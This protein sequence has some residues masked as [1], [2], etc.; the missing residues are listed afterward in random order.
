M[1]TSD[2]LRRLQEQ[3]AELEARIKREQEAEQHRLDERVLRVLK[4]DHADLYT[5]LCAVAQE[6]FEAEAVSRSERARAAARTRQ[7]RSTLSSVD[8]GPDGTND[9]GQDTDEGGGDASPASPYAQAS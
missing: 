2:R 7:R 3:H 8:D 4:T 6:Q 5:E 1:S 9:E